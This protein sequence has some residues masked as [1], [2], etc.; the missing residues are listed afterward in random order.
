MQQPFAY[1]DTSQTPRLNRMS[2]SYF[3]QIVLMEW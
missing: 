2:V 3:L 1:I